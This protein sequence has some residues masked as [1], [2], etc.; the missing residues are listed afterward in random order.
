[1]LLLMLNSHLNVDICENY[2]IRTVLSFKKSFVNG[3]FFFVYLN[4][5]SLAFFI[6]L[7]MIFNFLIIKTKLVSFLFISPNNILDDASSSCT[8]LNHFYIC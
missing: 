3:F 7:F 2:S 5:H 8:C 1:M 4:K 6:P